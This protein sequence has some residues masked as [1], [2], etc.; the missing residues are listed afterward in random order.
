MLNP[1]LARH[2]ALLQDDD[3]G[4]GDDDDDNYKVEDVLV[5][6]AHLP[7]TAEIKGPSENLHRRFLAGVLEPRNGVDVVV[8]AV[9]AVVLP[10]VLPTSPI[11]RGLIMGLAVVVV[12]M[13]NH[14]QSQNP[15]W[16]EKDD[17]SKSESNRNNILLQ[18]QQQK[19]SRVELSTLLGLMGGP[20][21]SGEAEAEETSD[22]TTNL[23]PYPSLQYLTFL[24]DFAQ[25]NAGLVET[26]DQTMDVLKRATATS[27]GLGL[28]WRAQVSASVERV[29]LAAMSRVRHR[30]ASGTT[31]NTD[32]NSRTGFTLSLSR[33]RHTLYRLMTR[34][35]TKLLAI[36]DDLNEG[37]VYSNDEAF[38][39]GDPP[40]PV[41]TLALLRRGRND[42]VQIL[43]MI[44]DR[45]SSSKEGWHLKSDA[46][47]SKQNLSMSL[48]NEASAHL[49]ASL[50]LSSSHDSERKQTP[51]QRRVSD[52][53]AQVDA[54]QVALIGCHDESVT[55]SEK[56]GAVV[57]DETQAAK[58]WEH[59]TNLLSEVDAT[60][61][62][63]EQDFFSSSLEP[64]SDANLE[65]ECYDQDGARSMEEREEFK[66]DGQPTHH[67]TEQSPDAQG[68][69]TFVFSGSGAVA[70]RRKRVEKFTS[71]SY[72]KPRPA[73]YD[74]FF[75]EQSLMHELRSHLQAMPPA[76]EVNVVEME[77]PECCDDIEGVQRVVETK[78]ASMREVSGVA[79]GLLLSELKAS[80]ISLPKEEQYLE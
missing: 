50:A 67:P 16:N 57:I 4:D 31:V 59:V 40:D 22:E 33:L 71:A 37:L 30:Q 63:V 69:R 1:Q 29:E 53:H 10:V 76:E 58:W 52:L 75:M 35:K 38:S 46:I 18:R 2:L 36:L 5:P 11:W 21:L 20:P 25:A 80:L 54:L 70:P 23:L 15:L 26:V 48:A 64:A 14:Y 34:Q 66:A 8:V 72:E 27:L 73:Q 77:V 60:R 13:H 68:Q 39:R 62:T 12:L 7:E 32:S 44:L 43:G 9:A 42:L 65:D 19:D 41:V 61:R 45:C 55:V 17:N 24:E 49:L 6:V 78:A 28:G 74:S 79:S 3:D 56:D 47:K 51:F